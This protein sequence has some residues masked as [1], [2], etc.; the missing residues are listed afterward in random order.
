MACSPTILTIPELAFLALCKLASPLPSPGPRCMSVA[1][2]LSSIRQK[3]SAAP[4]TTPSNSARTQRMPSTLSSAA[5]KCISDVPGLVKHTLTPPATRVR[6]RLSAPFI[7]ASSASARDLARR[8]DGAPRAQRRDLRG[9]QAQELAEHLVGVLAEHG[10]GRPHRAR[11]LRQAHRRADHPH[12]AG[13][14]MRHL[15][16]RL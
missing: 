9:P 16:Q 15:D 12:L 14:G 8:A 10:R 5:T 11:R 7:V 3:P 2:G 6:A 13:P 4:V 1:A